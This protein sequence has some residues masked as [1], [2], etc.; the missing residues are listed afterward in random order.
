MPLRFLDDLSP[1]LESALHG[2]DAIAESEHRIA[3]NLAIVA[4]IIRSATVKLRND[5][6]RDFDAAVGVLADLSI[7]IEAIAQLHRL[8]IEHN[9]N[10]IELAKYLLD[11]VKAATLALTDSDSRVAFEA[12]TDVRAHAS[13]AA[14]MGLFLCEAITNALKHAGGAYI[15]VVLRMSGND[16]VLEV[17][18]NGPGLP[19]D[20]DERRSTGFRLMHSLASRLNGRLALSET[21]GTGLCVRVIVPP[22]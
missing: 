12:R 17:T 3:N 11:V 10:Q 2:G 4:A 13:R 22:L 8:L 20:F 5:P 18:D 6:K 21:N 1:D 16:L 15:H 14:A 7:R 9:Q 19:S